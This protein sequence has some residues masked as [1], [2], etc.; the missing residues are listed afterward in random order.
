MKTGG[1]FDET[2]HKRRRRGAGYLLWWNVSS[3][4]RRCSAS[5]VIR[6]IKTETK[7]QTVS[8]PLGQW[9][10]KWKVITSIDK[11]MGTLETLY[12]V[13][14]DTKHRASFFKSY[15]E[16]TQQPHGELSAKEEWQRM[17]TCTYTHV[18][19]YTRVHNNLIHKSL[20]CGEKNNPNIHQLVNG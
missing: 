8:H 18:Y 11:V 9:K 19:M 7:C 15:T 1:V 14:V 20:K 17:C 2:F 12:I 16:M 4:V 10:S 6:K 3:N 13:G 5:L